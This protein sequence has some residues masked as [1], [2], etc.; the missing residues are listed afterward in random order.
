[1]K[2]TIILALVALVNFGVY[3][4]HDHAGHDAKKTEATP[5][6]N[7]K[8]LGIAYTHYIHLKDALIASN[9]S[10]AKKAASALQIS[11]DKVGNGKKASDSAA[12]IASSTDLD[13]QRIVFSDL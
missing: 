4:Q 10:E 6:F 11:L 2:K 12:M 3:A 5:M 8:K 1:M 7:D 13:Q 9:S